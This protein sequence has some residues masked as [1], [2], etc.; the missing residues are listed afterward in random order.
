MA[1]LIAFFGRFPALLG[2]FLVLR[3]VAL[4][5]ANDSAQGA[6]TTL[7]LVV[8]VEQ[9]CQELSEEAFEGYAVPAPGLAARGQLVGYRQLHRQHLQPAVARAIAAV[10]LAGTVAVETGIAT[11]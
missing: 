2:S 5:P 4:V 10:Q 7:A 1:K 3:A 9:Y 11:E 8:G 6:V